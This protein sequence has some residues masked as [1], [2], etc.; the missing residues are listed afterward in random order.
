MIIDL[1]AITLFPWRH[2]V[3]YSPEWWGTSDERDPVPALDGPLTVG[4]EIDKILEGYAVSGRLSG[5]I[6]ARCDRCIE[7]YTRALDAEFRLFFRSPPAAGFG[8]EVVLSKEDLLEDFI[9][10]EKVDLDE[11]VRE[12]IYLSL[13]MKSL[14]GT[15]CRGLCQTCGANLNREDCRCCPSGGHPGFSKLKELRSTDSKENR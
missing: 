15:E 14:C 5:R 2:E 1:K 12:Q 8:E 7:T 11:I 9:A 6:V 3:A 10:E 13:P 4:V